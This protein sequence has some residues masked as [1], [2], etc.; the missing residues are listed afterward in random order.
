MITKTAVVLSFV[1]LITG[2]A[3]VVRP[4]GGPVDDIAPEITDVLPLPGSIENI[5]SDVTFYFSEKIQLTEND[6]QIYPTSS[7]EI[8]IKNDRIIID[9]SSNFDSDILIITLAVTIQDTH[10]N[11]LKNPLTYVWNT[12]PADSFSQVEI[13]VSRTGGG[14]VTANA[15][16]DFFLLPDTTIPEVTFFPDSNAIVNANWISPGEYIVQCYEDQDLSRS[17]DPDREPGDSQE[18]ELI[19]GELNQLSMNMTIIDSIGPLVSEIRVIDNFHLEILWNEQIMKNNQIDNQ[20]ISITSPDSTLLYIYGIQPFTGRSNSGRLT[21]FTEQMS[22][23]S[24][25]IAIKNIQDLSGN[26][27]LPDSLDFWGT[28]SLPQTVFAVQSAFPPDGGIEVPPGGPFTISFSDWVS[29]DELLSLYQ[30]VR[31]AD[32]TR[33]D[34][35]LVRTS[36]VAFSFTPIN[37][38]LGNRQYRVDL[39]PGLTSLRGDTISSNSWIFI[40]AWSESPGSVSGR[41]SGTGASVVKM[42]VAPTGNE[43][44]TIISSFAPGEYFL[45]GVIGGRYTVA[46]FVDWNNDNVWNIGEP[47]G[48]WPGVIE[49]FPGIATEN[50]NIQVLP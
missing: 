35:R 32:S 9:N 24:Y 31:V 44:D 15:R 3:K 27:S 4:S 23:T 41:I 49:V 48:A 11:Q 34:G 29:L 50:I 18:L 45:A 30:V 28:D 22:D 38:L 43:A 16:C 13:S 17:W 7:G 37:E 5:P 2:C 20:N 33:V 1:L 19:A 25:T 26:S 10:G 36:P 8:D 21:V 14:S 6:I 40:P 12:V 46:V 42:V 47:Y 39:L